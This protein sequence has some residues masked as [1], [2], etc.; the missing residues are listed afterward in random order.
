[1]LRLPEKL[2]AEE[3]GESVAVARAAEEAKKKHLHE[4]RL[5]KAIEDGKRAAEHEFAAEKGS[6]ER[7]QRDL[8][9][10]FESPEGDSQKAGAAASPVQ[11]QRPADVNIQQASLVQQRAMRSPPVGASILGKL[12][13][14]VHG[15]LNKGE[16]K[17]DVD[18]AIRHGPCAYASMR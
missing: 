5:Q 2:Q 9:E 6:P 14:S 8:A 4:L 13:T 12:F 15:A 18:H 3:E 17:L 10:S 7:V 11:T 1:M 16:K